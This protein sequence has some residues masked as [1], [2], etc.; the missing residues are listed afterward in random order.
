MVQSGIVLVPDE[1][2]FLV[3][4]RERKAYPDEKALMDLDQVSTK[5]ISKTQFILIHKMNIDQGL[6]LLQLTQPLVKT[7]LRAGPGL[8][9]SGF[10]WE[11]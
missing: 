3:I 11:R 5:V 10:P 8:R 4:N 7:L 2:H 1:S 9:C 6:L